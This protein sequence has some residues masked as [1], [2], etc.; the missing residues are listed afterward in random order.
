MDTKKVW[1]ITG[2][3]KG[4]GLEF[5]KQ[6]LEKGNYVAATS[7]SIAQLETAAGKHD[8]FLPLEVNLSSE[9]SVEKAINAT[10]EKFGHIDN[11]VNNA[12]YG[13]LGSLEELTDAEARQNFEVNVFGTL[14]II[15]KVMPYLR[16]QQSGHIFNIS[17]IGGFVGNFPG[18]GI[19]CATKFAMAGFT[20]ALAAEAKAFNVNVTL[21]LPGYFRTNFLN[22]DSLAI[23]QNPMEEYKSTR[24]SQAMHQNTING[25][26]QGDPVKGV[27]AMIKAS[28]A[29][30]PPLYL[31]LG[32]DSVSMAQAKIEQLSQEIKEWESLSRSTDF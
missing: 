20:E 25:N 4:L 15:R 14:N 17:S 18:F 22:S 7:R 3:S 29:E 32:S 31:Y 5:V 16:K 2:A 10:I 26:Q 23:T 13:L 8:N 30:T 12:G 6:L 28:E 9:E 24:D 19:Y 21:V 27:T 11:V 1:F